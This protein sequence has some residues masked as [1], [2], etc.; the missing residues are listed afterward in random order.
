[1]RGSL[2]SELRKVTSTRMWWIMAL[3]MFGYMAFLG[4]VMAFSLAA[5]GGAE[6][7]TG[8]MSTEPLP[9]K[10]VALAAY[11]LAA[12]LGYVFPLVVGAL[13]MTGEFRHQTITPTLLAEPRRG[14][15]LAAKLVASCLVGL[16]HGLLGTLGAVVGA[17]PVLGLMDKP[18][19]LGDGD[20][21]TALAFSVLALTIW[22]MIGV[23]LGTMLTNQVAAVVVILAFTQFVEPIL[24]MG[25]AA[26][27]AL[28]GVSR[29][30]PGAAAEALVGAS[31]YSATGL[32][33]LLSR[34]EGGL[35]LVGYAVVFALIGRYTTLRR[36][37]S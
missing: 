15:L 16:V 22:A 1:M 10:E 6:A 11:T 29:F 32:A 4:A 31:L 8:G 2:V 24:R 3:L 33:T 34:W 27:D 28:E 14:V 25:F 26:V 30:F 37:I 13:A 19:L 17:A 23:G 5:D 21:L 35:V 7:M 20:V 18:L 9:A 36:D 12:A